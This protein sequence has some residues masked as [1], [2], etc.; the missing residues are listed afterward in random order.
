[1]PSAP[2]TTA[3]ALALPLALAAPASTA[4]PASPGTAPL[5]VGGTDA[6]EHY[7]G[8]VSLHLDG[9]GPFCGGTLIDPEWVVTA[10]HCTF[11]LDDPAHPPKPADAIT[12]RCGT[13]QLHHGPTARVETIVVHPGW[14]W[15]ST[16]GPVDDIALIKLT[17]PVNAPPAELTD[18]APV[19]NDE[20]RLLG[21]GFT[22]PAGNG[23]NP[24]TLQEV[25]TRVAPAERCTAASISP[26]EVCVADELPHV[27]HGEHERPGACFGDSGAPALTRHDQNWRVIGWASRA[28]GEGT[29]TP[30]DG[31]PDVY[32]DAS[33]YQDWIDNVID[34]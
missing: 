24:E 32:T 8:P 31:Q 30:C 15:A 14:D 21:W 23:P 18:T 10:A 17:E 20:V 29:A 27:M 22:D 1:M 34:E 13:Q 16:P 12:V 25:N 26:G 6:T 9:R 5:I 33:H 3:I 4:A 19:R 7:A 2:R 11:A 28:G